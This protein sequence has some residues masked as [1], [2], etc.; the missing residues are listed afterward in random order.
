MRMSELEIAG[1]LLIAPVKNSDVRGFFSETF[2][3]DKFLEK[4]PE[5]V[6]VQDNHARS[7]QEAFFA[8]CITRRRHPRREN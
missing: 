6:F 7:M 8:A 4:V 2:R 3:A 1:V 5:G